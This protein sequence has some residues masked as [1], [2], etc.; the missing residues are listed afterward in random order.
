MKRNLVA[1]IMS[2]FIGASDAKHVDDL[3]ADDPLRAKGERIGGNFTWAVGFLRTNFPNVSI[4]KLA[5]LLWDVCGSNTVRLGLGPD[6]P[7]LTFGLMGH[8]AMLFA[9]NNWD[10]MIKAEPLYQMGG[11]VFCGA[12]V[13]DFYS[14]KITS[15]EEAQVTA[16]RSRGYEAEYILTLQKI[17]RNVKLNEYQQGLLKDFPQ[18]L[19]DI[20]DLVYEYPKFTPLPQA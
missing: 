10:E 1:E 16:R 5:V 15:T 11:V 18:G 17:N 6:V 12:Q 9:P 4:R 3:P 8:D 2:G 7:T 20:A 14:G 13:C 19:K